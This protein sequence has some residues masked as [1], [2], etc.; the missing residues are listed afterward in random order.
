[1]KSIV[2]KNVIKTGD[3]YYNNETHWQFPQTPTL[4]NYTLTNSDISVTT[5]KEPLPCNWLFIIPQSKDGIKIDVTY[6][7]TG[8]TQT[9]KTLTLP[10]GNWQAGYKYTVYI[11]IGKAS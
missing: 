10:S 9:T 2:L 3:Y 6:T 7:K 4:S 5:N 11:R 1:M 8:E